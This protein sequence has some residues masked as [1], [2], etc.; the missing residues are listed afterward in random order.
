[1]VLF[2]CFILVPTNNK[3][4]KA[5]ASIVYTHRENARISHNAYG[6]NIGKLEGYEGRTRYSKS[7]L[8]KYGEE[9][10][11]KDILL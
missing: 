3:D 10:Y 5:I 11:I 7:K 4:A 6:G 9:N 1:M 2:L 8:D